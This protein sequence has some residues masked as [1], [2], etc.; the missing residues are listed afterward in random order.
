MRVTVI[1]GL[2]LL[3]GCC[4]SKRQKKDTIWK[5][6]IAT[7]YDIDNGAKSTWIKYTANGQN[8]HERIFGWY[9]TAVIGE[10]YLLHYDST[11]PKIYEVEF[12]HQLFEPDELTAYFTGKIVKLDEATFWDKTVGVHINSKWE[13]SE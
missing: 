6:A 8:Y 4:S 1:F 3:I 2:L 13:I 11:N 7:V 5:D 12:W 9:S 10:K